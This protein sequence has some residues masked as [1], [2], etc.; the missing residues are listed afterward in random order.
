MEGDF[1]ASRFSSL[2]VILAD[3]LEED[4]E[5]VG[6]GSSPKLF[7]LIFISFFFASLPT[8]WPDSIVG[9]AILGDL[10]W[11]ILFSGKLKAVSV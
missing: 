5:N 7:V 1:P 10:L 11:C 9:R 6:F 4:L 2:I 8:N 3:S